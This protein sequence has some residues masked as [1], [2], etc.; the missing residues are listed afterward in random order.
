MVMMCSDFLLPWVSPLV[1]QNLEPLIGE[2]RCGCTCYFRDKNN[3]RPY[4]KIYIYC[5]KALFFQK[6]S[7]DR[8]WII[9]MHDNGIN[10]I[11][12]KSGS[13]PGSSSLIRWP[14]VTSVCLQFKS[15]FIDSCF[16]GWKTVVQTW[17]V[18]AGLRTLKSSS[19]ARARKENGLFNITTF[20]GEM[21]FSVCSN[22]SFK[23]SGDICSGPNIPT[24]SLILY[25][26]L[27]KW[28][29][30]GR[31]SWMIQVLRAAPA[32]P[33]NLGLVPFAEDSI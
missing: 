20:V 4:A 28:D 29:S 12:I 22:K 17:A 2:A 18:W 19:C 26:R 11:W 3:V 23:D 5:V 7:S 21:L 27:Y 8:I 9:F 14:H 15:L 1:L 16:T 13:L 25:V 30:V 33:W 10:T 6:W 31:K 32:G 24:S